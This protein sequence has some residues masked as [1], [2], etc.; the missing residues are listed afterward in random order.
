[1]RATA[2]IVLAL[3]VGLLAG[4]APAIDALR[5]AVA[6]VTG[7][8][9]VCTFRARTGHDCL[10]CGGT[11]AFGHVARGHLVAG[12]RANPLGAM[13]GIAAWA[14]TAAA[15]VSLWQR[16]ARPLGLAAA[17]AMVALGV[18]FVVHALLW[19]RALPPD[20]ALW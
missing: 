20:V 15:L 8:P 1:M 18:T 6:S 16:R 3:C 19:W 17:A 11:R 2:S 10:G 13:V 4:G 9:T 7:E 5:G 14:L 12:F